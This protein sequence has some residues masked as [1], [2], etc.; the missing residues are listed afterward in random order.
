M[1]QLKELIEFSKPLRILYVEDDVK[2]RENY[3]KVFQELFAH[4]D[5]AENG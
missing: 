2:I 3:L 1:G 5:L 4:V